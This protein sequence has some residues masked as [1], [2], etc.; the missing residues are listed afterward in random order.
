MR[1][2]NDLLIDIVFGSWYIGGMDRIPIT[3]T[4][5]YEE[6]LMTKSELIKQ[7]ENCGDDIE[8]KVSAEYNRDGGEIMFFE[9][10]SV[11]VSDDK[12]FP[13]LINI[14]VGK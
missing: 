14:S 10:E 9:I 11:S 1:T 13:L 3:L 5:N 6:E 8:V 2:V 4:Q 7:I 12:S